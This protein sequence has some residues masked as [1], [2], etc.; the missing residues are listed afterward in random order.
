MPRH[1]RWFQS[2]GAGGTAPESKPL[3][4]DLKLQ[5][6][7]TLRL[8]LQAGASGADFVFFAAKVGEIQTRITILREFAEK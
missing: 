7:K 8:A 6:E 1:C 2:F 5:F 4:A 3:L